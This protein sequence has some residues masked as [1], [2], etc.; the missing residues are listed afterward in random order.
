M[1]QLWDE[2]SSIACQISLRPSKRLLT[3]DSIQAAFIE[4]W[5]PPLTPLL[6]HRYLQLIKLLLNINLFYK[7]FPIISGTEL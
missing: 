6:I 2:Q 4:K 7:L 1:E 5:I 3:S